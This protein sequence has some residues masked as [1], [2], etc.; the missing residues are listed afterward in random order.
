MDV[1]DPESIRDALEGTGGDFDILLDDSSHDIWHQKEIIR[2]ALP[3]MKPGG[4]ILIEDVF[5]NLSDEEYMRVIEPVKD[6]LSFYAFFE[7]EHTNKW[8]PG[9]DNDKILMLVKR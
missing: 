7:M 9:W 5:R 6:Q 8:S 3:F 1:S 4:I 2:E